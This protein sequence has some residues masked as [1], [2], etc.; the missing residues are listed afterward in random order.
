M[1]NKFTLKQLR[2]IVKKARNGNGL[3]S[4]AK[5]IGISASTLCRFESGKRPSLVTFIKICKWLKIDSYDEA[6]KDFTF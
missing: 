1:L 6:I 3:R 5:E 2:I 4:V